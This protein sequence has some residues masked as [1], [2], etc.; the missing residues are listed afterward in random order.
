[1]RELADG[2]RHPLQLPSSSASSM[3]H[4][5]LAFPSIESANLP[6]AKG[7]RGGGS[8]AIPDAQDWNGLFKLLS[9]ILISTVGAS[10]AIFILSALTVV[11]VLQVRGNSFLASLCLG[12]LIVS[13]FILPSTAVSVMSGSK[14][15]SP[16]LCH[17]QWL[18]TQAALVVHVLSFLLISF[19]CWKG[20]GRVHRY[21]QCCSKVRVFSVV[22]AIWLLATLLLVNQHVNGYGP[23]VCPSLARASSNATA[24][25]GNETRAE[26]Q[27]E[28]ARTTARPLDV[29]LHSAIGILVILL[30]TLLTLF[31]FSRSLVIVKRNRLFT[32]ENPQTPIYTL[33]DQNLL[34]SHVAVYALS[35]C[36]WT[37]VC[38]VGAF[39]LSLFLPS[40]LSLW[41]ESRGGCSLRCDALRHWLDSCVA[42]ARQSLSIRRRRRVPN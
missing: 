26:E 19:D 24:A 27:E 17:F 10:G 22:L 36:M 23:D 11:S 31:F 13:V 40:S 3:M 4:A 14:G 30:P 29:P 33:T 15:L 20:L 38:V 1:M 18:A 6:H 28:E 12:H 9:Y 32:L 41:S 2:S 25:A 35:L 8:A 39:S 7:V 42:V 21:N 5:Y 37:P 16:L 34:K